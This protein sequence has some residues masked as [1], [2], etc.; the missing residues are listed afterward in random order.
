M[1]VMTVLL[2]PMTEPEYEA[3]RTRSA[4]AYAD[5]RVSNGEWPADGAEQRA[6]TDQSER[7]PDGA[8]SPGALLL[9]AEDEEGLVGWLW[10]GPQ[11]HPGGQAGAPGRG[12]IF[13]I[14]VDDARRGHGLG[15]A[16]LAAAEQ[17]AREAG[18]TSI[19]LNVFGANTVAR[20]LYETSGY[21]VDAQQMSKPL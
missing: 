21:V 18:Y 17:A 1:T 7:L 8:G 3:F 19:G 4:R 10:L 6:L 9:R 5:H 16:L 20:T 11:W 12:W 14:E 2:H 15:R 13:M